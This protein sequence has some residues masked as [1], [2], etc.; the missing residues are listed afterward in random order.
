GLIK[1]IYE[2]SGDIDVA[3][4][5]GYALFQKELGRVEKRKLLENEIAKLSGVVAKLKES[6]EKV[7]PPEEEQRKIWEKWYQL[8]EQSVQKLEEEV[9]KPFGAWSSFD[10]CVSDMKS[11]GYNEESARKICGSLQA[12]LEK[13]DVK[14]WH[15]FAEEAMEHIEMAIE[16]LETA[17]EDRFGEV[18]DSLEDACD[19]LYDLVVSEVGEE[20]LDEEGEEVGEEELSAMASKSWFKKDKRPPKRWW[21]RCVE[22]TGRP[23]LCGWVY[24]HHLK[25]YKPASKRTPDEPHTAEARER[26]RRT[27]T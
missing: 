13:A 12:K 11:K 6:L 4:R 21:D 8:I 22:A 1:Q 17:G 25:P 19:A 23:A 10:D 5:I 20:G 16:V 9:R 26:K 7:E 27:G 15:Q 18:L 2:E 3:V 14:K 24:Y